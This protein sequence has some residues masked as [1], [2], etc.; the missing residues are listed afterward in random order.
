MPGI[1]LYG[2][3]IMMDATDLK[4]CLGALVKDVYY[5]G[6]DSSQALTLYVKDSQSKAQIEKLLINKPGFALINVKTTNSLSLEK[7]KSLEEILSRVPHQTIIFDPTATIERAQVMVSMAKQARQ[8]LGAALKGCYFNSE[9]RNIH[10][11]LKAESAG[12]TINFALI[13]EQLEPVI[14]KNTQKLSK[15]FYYSITVSAQ[16]PAGK[17]IAVDKASVVKKNVK[18]LLRKMVNKLKWPLLVASASSSIGMGAANAA[19]SGSLPAVS[20]VNGWID[21]AG[22]YLHNNIDSG[23][24]GFV[25]GGLAMPLSH[26]FGAQLHAFDGSVAHTNSQGLDGYIFWR[27]PAQGLLGPHVAY[28]NS[29]HV[30]QTLYG[31]HGED[32]WK[33]L[34]FV[35]EAG[36]M[37]ENEV[38]GSYYAEAIVHWYA[39]PNLDLNLGGIIVQGDGAGQIGAE[40]QLGLA[41]LPGL[42]IFADAGVGAHSLNYGFLGLRYYFGDPCDPGKSLERRHREDMVPPTLD[43]LV[44]NTHENVLTP[45]FHS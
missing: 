24:G 9:R 37:H 7:T 41:S 4:E 26:D 45:R 12:Q 16:N 3:F 34:T 42:S 23:G 2:D 15:P 1:L 27:N 44:M 28:T 8:L 20:N 43:L 38:G 33:N 36:G 39:I 6:V 29:D 31:L 13:R 17:V 21:A 25:E 10:F 5:C 22:G 30:Y 11:T 14:L 18:G 32:Y 40:Y 35:G 19:N